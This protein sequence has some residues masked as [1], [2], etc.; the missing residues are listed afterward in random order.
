LGGGA[1]R[2]NLGRMEEGAGGLPRETSSGTLRAR[3]RNRRENLGSH[4]AALDSLERIAASSETVSEQIRTA[5]RRL[6]LLSVGPC[7]ETPPDWYGTQGTRSQGAEEV[8]SRLR[9]ELGEAQEERVATDE[10][11]EAIRSE[12]DDRSGQASDAGP[13][14]RLRSALRGLR[15]ETK[16]LDARLGLAL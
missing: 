8:L 5:E 12:L 4:E 6:N 3:R 9:E 15:Q 10:A 16:Q 2:N 1:W 7:G 11:L 14:V 13:V